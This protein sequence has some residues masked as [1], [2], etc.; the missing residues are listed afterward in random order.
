MTSRGTAALAG[1]VHTPGHT[2][3]F[4]KLKKF[5][6]LLVAGDLYHYPDEKTRQADLKVCTTSG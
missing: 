4:L 6:P 1:R 2:V 5:A 3:L